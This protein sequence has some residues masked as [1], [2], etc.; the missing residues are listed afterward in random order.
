MDNQCSE[1]I[2]SSSVCGH[3]RGVEDTFGDEEVDTFLAAEPHTKYKDFA[4]RFLLR[5]AEDKS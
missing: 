5:H 3:G 1:S 2:V 4:R